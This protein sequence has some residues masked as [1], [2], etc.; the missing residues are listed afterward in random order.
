MDFTLTPSQNDVV[1]AF[2]SVMRKYAGTERA[3]EVL[4]DEGY[5]FELAAALEDLGVADPDFHNEYGPL[6]SQILVEEGAKFAAGLPIGTELLV[7]PRLG[8]EVGLGPVA[9]LSSRQDPGVIFGSQATCLLLVGPDDVRRVDTGATIG[10]ENRTFPLPVAPVHLSPEA[11]STPLPVSVSDAIAW[12]RVALVGEIVGAAEAALALT[13]D[14]LVSRHQFG[15]PLASRQ[16]IQHRLSE[17]HVRV[18]GAR[19]LGRHAAYLEADPVAAAV[20]AEYAITAGTAAIWELQ[21]LQGATG[22]TLEYDLHLFT[23]R[24]HVLRTVLNGMR[25]DHAVDVA[26]MRWKA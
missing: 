21:Q 3:R 11:T 1:S 20:A 12:Q 23:L 17:V 7:K 6:V 26:R 18:E 22:F 24:I 13:I 19:W 2:R 10:T 9:L 25:G 8:L 14:H 4:S 5:D 15:R 16:V